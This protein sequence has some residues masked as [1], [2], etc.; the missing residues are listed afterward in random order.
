MFPIDI[1]ENI[2]KPRFLV[3]SKGLKWEQWPGMG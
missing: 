2:E 1:P 3:F